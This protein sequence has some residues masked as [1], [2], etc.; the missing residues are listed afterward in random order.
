ML[1]NPALD[2]AIGLVFLYAIYSL[3]ATTL[4]ELIATWINLRGKYLLNGIK[5]M[6]DDDTGKVIDLQGDNKNL[7]ESF[8]ERPEILY[9]GR[10][11]KRFNRNLPS[12]IKAKTFSKS[13]LNVL[14]NSKLSTES[15]D[16]LK[17]KLDRKIPTQ[18][19]LYNLIEE[20]NNDINALKRLLEDWFNETMD[21]VAG[22]YKKRIQ[23]ITF[24]IGGILAFSMNVDTIAIAKQLS[25]DDKARI[26]MLN[27]ATNSIMA[28][29]DVSGADAEYNATLDSLNAQIQTLTEQSK[30]TRSIIDVKRPAFKLDKKDFWLSVLGC[31]LTT[32]ALSLGASFWFDLLNR[33][34]KLRG[35]GAQEETKKKETDT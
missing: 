31:L 7:S 8:Y 16:E 4:T 24:I 3:F 34:I 13:V 32:I 35:T 25:S 26:E 20:A 2:V 10:K 29:N 28:M 15:L 17:N 19:F 11:S 5:R 22:W 23:L 21:R 27:M 12:Y 30:I 18:A 14:L 33:L 6:L 1:N 9:L